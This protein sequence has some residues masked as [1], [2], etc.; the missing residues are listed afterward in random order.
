[1]LRH[2]LLSLACLVSLPAAQAADRIILV[3]DSTV[4]SGGGYGD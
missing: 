2:A 4:A 3:G 1:M